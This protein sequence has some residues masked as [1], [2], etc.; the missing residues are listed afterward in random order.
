MGSNITISATGYG[1]VPSALTVGAGPAAHG[2]PSPKHY[3]STKVTPSRWCTPTPL[4]DRHINHDSHAVRS[5]DMHSDLS[6]SMVD[7]SPGQR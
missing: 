1:T 3:A 2:S 7:E 6:A 4:A 5:V